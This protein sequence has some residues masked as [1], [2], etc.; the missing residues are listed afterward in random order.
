MFR[1]W[2]LAFAIGAANARRGAVVTG[3]F[4]LLRRFRADLK[5]G[6]AWF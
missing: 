3:P 6:A 5:R 1:Q 4:A 2:Q